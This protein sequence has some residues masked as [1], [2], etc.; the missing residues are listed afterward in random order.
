MQLMR[1]VY[2]LMNENYAEKAILSVTLGGDKG[3]TYDSKNNLIL[4]GV[5]VV[6]SGSID[7]KGKNV[8]INP[9]ETKSYNKH[10]EVKRGFS[11][12]FS[13]KGIS[14][15]YGKDKFS[16]DTDI[17]NNTSKVV[18]AIKDGVAATNSLMNYKYVGTDSTGAETLKNKPNI[19]NASI[20]Y[21]KSC[22]GQV[23]L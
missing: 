16:S 15:L 1:Q 5:K 7:L 21:N 19:F 14:V 12:S 13:P 22:S 8:E 18:G 6:S 2:K 23:K 3:L 20:S 11:G 4:S 9:L 10:K 17:L